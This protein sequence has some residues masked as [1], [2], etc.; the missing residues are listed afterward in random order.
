[1]YPETSVSVFEQLVR[2]AVLA[3]SGDNLQPWRFSANPADHRIYVYLDESRDQSPMNCGQRMSR[4]AIGA[5]IENMVAVAEHNGL[6]ST[7]EYDD[8]PAVATVRIAGDP[9]APLQLH[10]S[11]RARVTNRRFYDGRTVPSER[12]ARIA[13]QVQALPSVSVY[14]IYERERLERLAQLI[15]R[16]DATMFRDASI[17]KAFRENIRFEAGFAGEVADGLSLEHWSYRLLIDSRY[18][19]WG[20]YRLGSCRQRVR[21]MPLQSTRAVS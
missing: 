5:A 1:M 6:K 14:W 2:A 19:S 21:F 3:P 20:S 4:I 11:V 18:G 7:V 10:P 8:P 9:A 13:Q 15:G 16:A 12:R 17:R